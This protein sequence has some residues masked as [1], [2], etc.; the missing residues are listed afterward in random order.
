MAV[1]CDE[2]YAPATQRATCVVDKATNT[3]GSGVALKWGYAAHL[4]LLCLVDDAFTRLW[5]LGST[6]LTCALI[7]PRVALGQPERWP[8]SH[9]RSP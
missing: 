8:F 9:V 7:T 5:V 2:G 3:S 6:L 1:S 4:T